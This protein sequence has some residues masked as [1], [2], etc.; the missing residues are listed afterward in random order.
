MNAND[1][2]A[3]AEMTPIITFHS[4]KERA[5]GCNLLITI[6]AVKMPSADAVRPN[7]P[8]RK[9]DAEAVVW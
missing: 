5:L 9:L 4:V 3:S 1:N 2:M 7:V 6:P 8:V